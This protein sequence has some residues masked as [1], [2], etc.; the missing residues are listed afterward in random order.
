MFGDVMLMLDE[1]VA[2]RLLGV[3]SFGT[4][5]GHAVNDVGDEIKAVQVVHHH[6]GNAGRKPL[7]RPGS[8]FG[9]DLVYSPGPQVP[10]DCEAVWKNGVFGGGKR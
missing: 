9:Q 10:E 7:V 6:A 4:E 8:R 1:L 3:G 5:L 2:D